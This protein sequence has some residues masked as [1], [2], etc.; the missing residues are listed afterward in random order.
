LKIAHQIDD[1]SILDEEGNY[2]FVGQ[3]NFLERVI[4]G[5][6]CFVCA[7]EISDRNDE[8][9]I[10]DW[11]IRRCGLSN[12]SIKLPNQTLF[13]YTSYKI[14][15][16]KSC[17]KF[18]GD[19]YEKPISKAFSEG[20]EAVS[21]LLVSKPELLF[22]WLN[23][24]VFKTHFK[25]LSLRSHLDQRIDSDM[26][27]STYDWLN[28]HH[29]H[30]IFRAPLFQTRIAPE[31]LGSVA[32]LEVKDAQLGGS[33]DYRDH[34]PSDTVYIRIEDISIV[35]VLNDSGAVPGML[36][37]RINLTDAPDLV[38]CAEILT[39]YQ[40]ASMHLKNRPAF[41][42]RFDSSTGRFEIFATL[43]SEKEVAEYNPK[44]RGEAFWFNLQ[45]YLEVEIEEG[46]K[47]RDIREDILTGRLTFL[48]PNAVKFYEKNE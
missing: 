42:T 44:M 19:Y 16:C 32:L 5:G 10:P 28:F 24:I 33:F 25:D 11:I 35:S 43:P 3:S 22:G 18:L 37:G 27:G 6:F 23:L 20:I 13:K 45:S 1:G 46:L 29:M 31:V 40:V 15:C 34:T 36:V 9:I 2:I 47:I 38:Q 4:Q 41:G 30:A 14:P 17:N 8:H 39:E 48:S 12:K 7:N 26:I 21:E